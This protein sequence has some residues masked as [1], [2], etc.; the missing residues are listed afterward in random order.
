[1]QNLS[2]LP[3]SLGALSARVWVPL[4]WGGCPISGCREQNGLPLPF[5][6]LAGEATELA[7]M[8][9]S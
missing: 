9:F 1:M 4:L 7:M 6:H 8:G 2:F 5:S 3:Q